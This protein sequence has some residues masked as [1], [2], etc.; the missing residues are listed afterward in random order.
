MESRLTYQEKQEKNIKL[1]RDNLVFNVSSVSYSR[2]SKN[3]KVESEKKIWLTQDHND[4][5]T[6]SLVVADGIH[7]TSFDITEDQLL[8]MLERIKEVK[9]ASL[10]L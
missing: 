6:F 10:N 9:Q 7:R 4:A 2:L 5:L 3:G 8:A 1:F